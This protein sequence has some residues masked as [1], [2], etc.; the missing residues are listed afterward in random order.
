MPEK[1]VIYGLSPLAERMYHNFTRYS[2]YSVAAF[3]V[4]QEYLQESSFCG[5]PVVA[6]QDIA[7]LYPADEYKMFVAIGFKRMRDRSIMFDKAKAQGYTLVNFISP[8]AIVCED[9]AIGENN[10]IQSS[11]DIDMFVTIGN[12]NIIWTN[13]I[14]GHDTVIGNHNYIAGSC[15]FGGSCVIGNACFIGNAAITI[16]DIHIADETYLVAGAVILRNTEAACQ[17]HGNPAKRIGRHPETGIVIN[18]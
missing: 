18:G 13:S 7:E 9:L 5:L 1:I 2:P 15:G 6:F 14:I 10:I 11:V 12:N 3:C 16:N 8:R 17:Y 4:D